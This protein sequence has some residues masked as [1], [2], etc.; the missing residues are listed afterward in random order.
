MFATAKARLVYTNNPTVS[1][2][3]KNLTGILT[4]CE[5]TRATFVVDETRALNTSYVYKID[6]HGRWLSVQ[7]NHSVYCFEAVV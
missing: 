2:I 6:V 7:T 5:G 1:K 3:M 4:V